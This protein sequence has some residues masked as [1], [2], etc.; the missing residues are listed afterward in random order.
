[1]NI[2][3]FE[4]WSLVNVLHRDL[5]GISARR[6]TLAD[7]DKSNKHVA[8]WIPAVDIIEEKEQFVLYADIP[9]VKPDDINVSMEK[10]ILSISGQRSANTD[11][12]GDDVRKRER[13]TGIFYRQFTLP[14]SANGE[15]ISAASDLG[16]LKV[17]IAKQAQV[18][19]RR[20]MVNSA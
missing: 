15:E 8:N 17:I 20:I 6:F 12:E 13:N 16:T 4:P 9:G 11:E 10:G 1:M 5:D 3:R 2:S 7:N 18:K 14:E 19:S